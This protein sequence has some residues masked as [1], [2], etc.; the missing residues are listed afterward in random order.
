MRVVKQLELVDVEHH[1]AEAA[2]VA[3][4][5]RLLAREDL[6]ELAV[7]GEAGQRVALAEVPQ[8][9][10]QPGVAHRLAGQLGQRGRQRHLALRV[11]ALLLPVPEVQEA[12]R[13]VDR[14]H[15]DGQ[16]ALLPPLLEVRPAHRIEL[17]VGEQAEE[18]L[19]RLEHAAAHRV[20]R[21]LRGLPQAVPAARRPLPHRPCDHGVAIGVV[22]VGHALGD[23]E[24]L[25]GAACHD[26][27][28]LFHG[29]GPGDGAAGLEQRRQP[30]SA[31]LLRMHGVRVV[32]G[33]GDQ[34]A[35]RDD[36]RDLL[37]RDGAALT[38]LAD[39][40]QPDDLVPR[41]QRHDEHGLLPPA[42]HL[43]ALGRAEARIIGRGDEDRLS[44]GE[45]LAVDAPHVPRRAHAQLLGAG[46][47]IVDAGEDDH[48]PVVHQPIDVRVGQVHEIAQAQGDRRP[49]RLRVGRG[50]ELGADVV[51]RGP[52]PPERDLIQPQRGRQQG[53]GLT[54]EQAGHAHV[55]RGAHGRPRE[56][57]EVEQWQHVRGREQTQGQQCRSP[58]K[59]DA[60]PGVEQHEEDAVD[61]RV[62][63]RQR[64][65]GGDQGE[66][67]RDQGQA[68]PAGPAAPRQTPGHEPDSQG[69]CDRQEG[70]A[71]PTTGAQRLHETGHARRPAEHEEGRGRPAHQRPGQPRTGR[72]A[73]CGI[74][75][76]ELCPPPRQHPAH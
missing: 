19:P 39:L 48:P 71:R 29:G 46:L 30:A 55:Q 9:T 58:G 41:D 33:H 68:G 44:G 69:Q 17:G 12:H 15:G 1:Q 25:S 35:D 18:R 60:D 61:D 36:R 62:G 54:D 72:I 26:G 76:R 70:A 24:H 47:L 14:L 3:L 40:D 67:H 43:V 2:A 16:A 34:P 65:G 45:S 50:G 22:L 5:P 66:S 6:V 64:D 11:G 4:G 75:L 57:A 63:A 28:R 38:R 53:Q 52:G 37:G 49:E 51:H 21:Q 23:P 74:A 13:T 73:L 27:E 8:A 20:L 42:A 31:R 7:V 56:L 59:G 32:E 10:Q